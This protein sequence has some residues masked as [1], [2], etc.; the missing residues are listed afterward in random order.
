M[1]GKVLV[2]SPKI[3][4]FKKILGISILEDNIKAFSRNAGHQSSVNKGPYPKRTETALL[5]KPKTREINVTKI[6]T[7][8]KTESSRTQKLTQLY[9]RFLILLV[10]YCFVDQI[11]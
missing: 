2:T 9:H 7:L 8:Q 4:L 5:E 1:S 10:I 6:I 11:N 3:G